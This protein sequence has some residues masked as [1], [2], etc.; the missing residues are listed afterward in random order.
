MR[1]KYL[2][3]PSTHCLTVAFV[4]A[5]EFFTY[6]QRIEHKENFTNINKR[7]KRKLQALT[8]QMNTQR[9][10]TSFSGYF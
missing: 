7:T 5:Q 4:E 8:Y 2:L 10:R 6:F 9:K 3:T 1:L